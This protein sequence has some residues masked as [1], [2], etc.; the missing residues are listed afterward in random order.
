LTAVLAGP[1]LSGLALRGKLGAGDGVRGGLMERRVCPWWLGYWLASPLRRI[2]HDPGAI[3]RPYVSEGMRVL[4]PGPGMGFLTLELARLVG[5]RGRVL[6][7]DV[8]A[9]MLESLR[10]RAR[11]AGVVDRIELRLAEP[12]SLGIADVALCIDFVLAF[13]MVHEVPDRAL[14]FREVTA[15]LKPGGHVLFAEPAWHVTEGDFSA[16]LALAA[17]AGLCLEG[18]PGIRSSRAALFVKG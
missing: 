3:L 12:R 8:Q 10:R 14:F 9:S 15:A 2:T 18:R 6:A 16:S 4:E 5:P 7:V 13:A 1:T 11:R 17:E